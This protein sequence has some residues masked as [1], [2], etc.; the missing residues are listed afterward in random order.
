[1]KK[2]AILAML[3]SVDPDDP[4]PLYSQIIGMIC[5]AL[6]AGNLKPGD[7]LPSTRELARAL[8]INLNTSARTY[9]DM[10]ALGLILSRRGVGMF[11]TEEAP[12]RGREISRETIDRSLQKS[13]SD[14]RK[15]GLTDTEILSQVKRFLSEED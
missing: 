3:Q 10:A 8:K 13:L 2:E 1:M 14:A 6:A 11:I 5:L 9:K 7:R 15:M 12:V 4:R